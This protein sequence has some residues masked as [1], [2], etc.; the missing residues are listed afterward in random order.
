VAYLQVLF[1]YL[2]GW[3]KDK[4]GLLSTKQKCYSLNYDILHLDKF[5]RVTPTTNKTFIYTENAAFSVTKRQNY[6]L[7]TF[8][9]TALR[10]RYHRVTTLKQAN[11]SMIRRPEFRRYLLKRVPE[12]NYNA[13]LPS[14][15]SI[16]IVRI[17][18]TNDS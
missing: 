12:G 10:V 4:Y 7:N 14:N 1:Q 13:H 2:P 8:L 15:I 5:Y 18:R 6:C 17:A 11:D 9:I 16:H 3:T